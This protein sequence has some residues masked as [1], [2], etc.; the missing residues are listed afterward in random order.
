[1]GE[2][3]V[4]SGGG[5]TSSF[6]ATPTSG[7]GGRVGDRGPGTGDWTALS[8]RRPTPTSRRAPAPAAPVGRALLSRRGTPAA[9]RRGDI[10][11]ARAPGPARALQTCR[12]TTRGLPREAGSG[13]APGNSES[14]AAG[15][16]VPAGGPEAR[17][18]QATDPRGD[19]GAPS[20]GTAAASRPGP[21][22]PGTT[23]AGAGQGDRPP[24]TLGGASRR[25]ASRTPVCLSVRLRARLL[26][27]TGWL[28]PT[29]FPLFP[30][31][32]LSAW[33][34]TLLRLFQSR[35][36]PIPPSGQ[37]RSHPPFLPE[38]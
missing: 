13:A 6:G 18:G 31:L 33:L 15:V 26:A 27:G 37:P 7:T 28:H 34:C 14:A 25:R 17:A 12:A 32:S 29:P 4:P 11:S 19:A 2:P 21:R 5:Y 35:C 24:V 9:A 1:M 36:T 38:T 23:G 20:R 10:G 22:P 8:G 3:G 30:S 16:A